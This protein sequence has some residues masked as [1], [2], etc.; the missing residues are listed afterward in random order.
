MLS[1]IERI[2]YKSFAISSSGDN[3]ILI[4]RRGKLKVYTVTFTVESDI[5]G[6][7]T[8]KLGNEIID[9]ARNPK[10]GAMYGFNIVPHYKEG[11]IND[12]LIVSLPTN[13]N[14]TVNVGWQESPIYVREV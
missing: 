1:S 3:T 11:K 4:P 6:E 2:E 5:T 7:V 9:G 13:V 8:I 14:T 10:T 12:N